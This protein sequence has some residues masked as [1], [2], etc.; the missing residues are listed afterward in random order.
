[1]PLMDNGKALLQG[2]LGW[3]EGEARSTGVEIRAI[4]EKKRQELEDHQA[5]IFTG[6]TGSW[7]F[8]TGTGV[9][10]AQALDLSQE[11]DPDFSVSEA[12]KVDADIFDPNIK[13]EQDVLK[14][15]RNSVHY[16]TLKERLLDKRE[17][18]LNAQ[19]MGLLP[20]MALQMVAEFGNV[21][22]YFTFGLGS[23]KKAGMLKR[24]LLSGAITGTAN[25]AEEAYI[26]SV[27]KDRTATD[28]VVAGAMGMGLGWL[29]TL[30]GKD[31]KVATHMDEVGSGFADFHMKNKVDE[32]IEEA[33]GPAPKG[34]SQGFQE[35]SA[36][37]AQVKNV[38]ETLD[39]DKGPNLKDPWMNEDADVVQ[40]TYQAMLQGDLPQAKKMWHEDIGLAS[41]S[42]SLHSSDNPITRFMADA[43]LEYPEGKGQKQHTAALQADLDFQ[44]FSSGYMKGYVDF[45]NEWNTL[46]KDMGLTQSFDE[47][48]SLWV[49]GSKSIESTDI[50]LARL[51]E[52][53]QMHYTKW[54]DWT[55]QKMKQAGVEEAQ[56]L[57]YDP[58][59]LYRGWD[60]KKVHTMRNKYDAETVVETFEGAIKEGRVFREAQE[61]VNKD[62]EKAAKEA[63]KLHMQGVDSVLKEADEMKARLSK[64]DNE[65]TPEGLRL[66]RDIEKKLREAEDLKKTAPA[67]NYK[68][69]DL[70]KEIKRI[71]EAMYHRFLRRATVSTADANLLST[72]NR[73][74]LN[75]ILDDMNL[76]K[77]D[78]GHI[79]AVL[80]SMGKDRQAN[81]LK[82]KVSMDIGY[83]H[84]SGLR[85]M[86]MMHTDLGSAYASKQRYWIG[87]AASAKRGFPSEEAFHKAIDELKKHGSDRGMEAKDIKA[88]VA[89][90][91][92]GWKMILGRPIEN[93]DHF[94]E[95][96]MRVVR[97]AVQVS[98]LGKLGIAQAAETGRVMSACGVDNIMQGIPLIKDMI[99]DLF[100]GRLDTV[101]LK[102]FESFFLGK[103]GDEHY[104][105]HPDFRVD[106]FGH[107]ISKAEKQLDRAAYWLSAASGW[108]GV[109]IQQKKLLMNHLAGR[110]YD[111]FAN[112]TI[113][114][115]QLEDLGIPIHQV[116]AIRDAMLENCKF[117]K[118]GIL[119]T[120][121][122]D[123]WDPDLRETIG[124]A[125]HRKSHN[126]IQ[127]ILAGETPLW[128]NTGLGKFLGQ[129]KTFSLAA[130]AKQTIHDWN[131]YKEGDREAALAFQFMLASATM[132][133]IARVGFN[134]ATRPADE[135]M[136]YLEGAL[137]PGAIAK[138][139]LGYHGQVGPLV[140][141][142]DL[143]A[144]QVTPDSWGRITGNQ[145]RQRDLLNRIP[146]VSY[147][148]NLGKGVSGLANA[149]NPYEEMSK[150]EWNA[151]VGSIP[152]S[153]WYGFYALNKKVVTPAIFNDR[154][155]SLKTF[156]QFDNR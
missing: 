63:H 82:H 13:E 132:A 60:G 71:A 29:G 12:M 106:D 80:E 59:H 101:A 119:L 24:V 133:Q 50:H 69:P 141:G 26:N 116:E 28:Y 35:G 144:S 30:G 46:T 41:M 107:A 9:A 48:A 134:A 155:H 126:A 135:R 99:A 53:F 129:F 95:T 98:M 8:E 15:A 120:Y 16:N 76:D 25:M 87:R 77:A 66:A 115:A 113:S 130:L 128:I 150:S 10:L 23:L 68:G 145:Y 81:P 93:M 67:P 2:G 91:E 19:D 111:W 4:E 152:L 55:Y 47:A 38:Y 112:E 124:M 147:I 17:F 36:G 117:D 74:L 153:S 123:N 94:G 72:A 96:A 40:R 140:D 64:M 83:E 84:P 102:D 33:M 1:M 154:G 22:N 5:S 136:D 39:P 78:R 43:L 121:N 44:Y 105:Q 42:Q 146:G 143:L 14:T 142:V 110:M 104:M 52:D 3:S 62:M 56:D 21:P 70:D 37:A 138:S 7:R 97:K 90:L 32:V 131:M 49:S 20:S 137:H 118:D 6:V 122:L 100:D 149:I 65:L 85:I 127:G 108:R 51:L 125:L 57:N 92:A 88:D 75:D 61:A 54:N 148:N 156:Q 109:Y 114:K 89:R 73:S 79:D 45:K 86:D 18:Q 58:N 11:Y 31:V 27:Y 103:I 139:I 34:T 151:L